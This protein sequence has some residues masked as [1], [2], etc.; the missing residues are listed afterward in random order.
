MISR[1]R[2]RHGRTAK[3]IPTA[4]HLVGQVTVRWNAR[5]T[6]IPPD[7]GRGM[8]LRERNVRVG[9]RSV[10]RLLTR[11]I[12]ALEPLRVGGSVRV[13][14]EWPFRL[15]RQPS[16][17]SAAATQPSTDSVARASE[18]VRGRRPTRR[19]AG[20]RY[21]ATYD[22]LRTGSR[23]RTKGRRPPVY[24]TLQRLRTGAVTA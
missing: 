6:L 10:R 15:E 4:S 19:A 1:S 11:T 18:E 17:F 13:D 24:S 9:T 21:V 2:N 16:V 7:H 8:K 23:T 5:L 3:W 20:T 14:N 12:V 22:P